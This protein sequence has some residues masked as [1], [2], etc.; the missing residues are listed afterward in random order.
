MHAPGRGAGRETEDA[1]GP[2]VR[3]WPVPV[4][5]E[6]AIPFADDRTHASYD[7]DA[8]NH[9]WRIVMEADRVLQQFRGGFLGKASPATSS[10]GAS[11]SRRR[12]SRAGARRPTGVALPTARPT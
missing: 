4:E 2:D 6:T 5:V 8:A 10:G 7:A 9:W 11:T 12:A 3:I 1:L